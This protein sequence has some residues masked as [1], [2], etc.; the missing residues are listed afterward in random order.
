MKQ[1][2]KRILVA[3]VCGVMTLNLMGCNTKTESASTSTATSTKKQPVTL[4]IA[5]YWVGTLPEAA[6]FKK[7]VEE[8]PKSKLGEGVTL[9]VEEIPGADAYAQK[10][11]LLIS[12]G[13]L[14]DIIQ[15]TGANYLDLAVK[16]GKVTD[17]TPYFNADE[18][19]KGL[20]D[21][22]SLDYNSRDG[23]IY[24]VPYTKE[25]GTMYYNKELFKKAGIAEFPKTWDEFFI[26]CEKLKAANITPIALD[27][28]EYGWF[29]SLMLCSMI[30]TSGTNG[31]KWMN[32]AFPKDYTSPEVISAFANIQKLFKNYTTKD[33]VGGNW[34]VPTNHFEKGEVAM[35][36]NGP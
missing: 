15:A 34:V 6:F 30:G 16:S 35:I 10:M 26:V 31:N 13:D 11:K 7:L 27:T 1:T 23:K 25:V 21:Q 14:P 18:D 19:W 24:G 17:L 32:T 2:T 28:A 36:A 5:T 12:S 9:E 8:F 29:T 22:K 20:F 3:M 33:A 4:K